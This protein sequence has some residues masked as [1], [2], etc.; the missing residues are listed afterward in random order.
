LKELEEHKTPFSSIA[1]KNPKLK[2]CL[3][4]NSLYDLKN[5]DHPGGNF[6][7]EEIYGIFLTFTVYFTKKIGREIGRFYFGA[8]ALENMNMKPYN[9]KVSTKKLLDK[10]FVGDLLFE[11]INILEKML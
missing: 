1:K 2:W 5:F 11:N 9:H 3:L 10:M 6:I 8:F 4:S 7:I